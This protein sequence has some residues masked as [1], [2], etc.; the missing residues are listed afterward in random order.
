MSSNEGPPPSRKKRFGE[1]TFKDERATQA[2][3]ERVKRDLA[4]EKARE[5]RDRASS[6]TRATVVEGPD[7]IPQLADL[8]EDAPETVRWD[9]DEG[10]EPPPAK[11]KP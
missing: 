3:A 1:A 5:G 8:P 2:Y 11:R 9:V 10:D 4:L 7:G 6:E